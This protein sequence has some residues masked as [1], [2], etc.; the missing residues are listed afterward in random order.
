MADRIVLTPI[1]VPGPYAAAA[2]LTWTAADATNKN[3]F[4]FT[5][6]EILLV[7]NDNAGEQTVTIQ[8]V[9]CEHA[10]TG[11]L[12]K[13]IAASA[14]AVFPLFSNGEGWRQTDGKIYVDAASADVKF[15][16]LR[17]P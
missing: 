1:S 12:S 11:N 17:I 7:R 3:A 13:A 15:C 10:R 14:Y 8:S 6:R 9:A 4:V 2:N 16:V 5:G